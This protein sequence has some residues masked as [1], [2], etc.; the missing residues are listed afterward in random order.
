MIKK[1]LLLSILFSPQKTIRYVLDHNPN[2]Y[3]WELSSIGG[4]IFLFELFKELSLGLYIPSGSIFLVTVI[5][6]PFIGYALINFGAWIISG[7]GTWIKMRGKFVNIRASYAYSQAPLLGYILIELFLLA[8]FGK[9][10]YINFPG[11]QEFTL[12]EIFTLYTAYVVQIIF[13]IWSV[14]ILLKTLAEARNTSIFKAILNLIIAFIIYGLIVFLITLP[15][16]NRCSNFFDYPE[17]TNNQLYKNW[18]ESFF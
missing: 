6:S 16:V 7:T 14:I 2:K 13:I 4:F 12:Q 18:Q 10:L 3:L 8:V 15:F 5:F 9:R 11:G 1:S 17:L